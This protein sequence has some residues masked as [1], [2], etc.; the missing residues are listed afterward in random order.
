MRSL[1][2]IAL[3]LT[4]LIVMTAGSENHQV[5]EGHLGDDATAD[6][7]PS[8]KVENREFMLIQAVS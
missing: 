8:G 7:S 1:L 5:D 6:D 2:I 4:V 3:A